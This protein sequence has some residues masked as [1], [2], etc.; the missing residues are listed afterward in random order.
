MLSSYSSLRLQNYKNWVSM[1]VIH[2]SRSHFFSSP[3]IWEIYCMT[4]Y[5]SSR[6]QGIEISI[7]VQNDCL[8]SRL[9]DAG[10]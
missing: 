1:F 7:V 9:Q 2:S 6:I 4:L 5:F 8:L 3:Q 10:L